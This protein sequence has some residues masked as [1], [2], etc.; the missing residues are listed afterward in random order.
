M[1]NFEIRK[2]AGGKIGEPRT[3]KLT[4]RKK[5]E[6][7][8]GGKKLGDRT[9][10][11]LTEDESVIRENKIFLKEE[12]LQIVEKIAKEEGFK[13]EQLEVVREIHDKAGRL[14]ALD[15]S[16]TPGR[17]RGEGFND[18]MFYYILKG[19]HGKTGFSDESVIMRTY[20]TPDNKDYPS[21]G[22]VV[23][24]YINGEWKLSPGEISPNAKDLG[25][26]E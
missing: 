9:P 22:G 4:G 26:L 18:I 5:F 25:P 13:K 23:G 3:E 20:S 2:I 8:P 15:V 6:V 17:A 21:S 1:A 24:R 16:V 10:K 7:L 19:V 14:V 12:I 11:I